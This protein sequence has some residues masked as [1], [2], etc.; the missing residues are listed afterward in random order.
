MSPDN[1]KPFGYV[2]GASSGIGLELAK[3]LARRGYDL[4]VA[5][6]DAGIEAAARSIAQSGAGITPMQV[7]LATYEGNE[8]LYDGIKATGRPVDVAVL[9]AGVG[10]GGDFTRET[11]LQ[12][13]INLIR[14]NVIS[15][16]HLAKRTLKDMVARDQG[17]VLI[18]SSI[19]A[20]MPGPYEACYAAS[21]AF[22]FSFSHAL[23]SELKDT[24]IT[25][26]ALMPG[27]TETNFF[28]RAGM[29][30]TKIGKEEKDDPAEVAREGIDALLSGEDHVVAGAMK[31][32][33]FAALGRL[34]PETAAE[35]HRREAE[36]EAHKAA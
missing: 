22:L 17:R 20:M 19:A 24:G 32:K 8:K 34:F 35:V 25:V 11:D 36:P 4:I 31:N 7:D 2:T 12:A 5:A 23:R 16:V 21:K 3:E 26:T 1:S 15:P 27:A 9:N 30:G 28:H 33:F 18:V 10:V 29:D 13:E 6:E 14:L